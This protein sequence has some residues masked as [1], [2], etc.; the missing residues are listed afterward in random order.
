MSGEPANNVYIT[1]VKN[2]ARCGG[3]HTIPFH[4]FADP[5]EDTWSHWGMCPVTNEPLLMR[6]LVMGR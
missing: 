6:I 3:D 4:Q 1:E 5:P 2:C